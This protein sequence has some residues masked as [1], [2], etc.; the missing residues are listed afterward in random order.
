VS[1]FVAFL[2]AINLGRTRKVPMAE[3]RAWLSAAGL[4]EVESYIQTG[5]LRF[6]TSMR[7]RS[8]VERLVEQ[9]LADAC[10]FDVPT[11]AF[12]PEELRLIHA[13]GLTVPVPDVPDVRRYVTF[14]KQEPDTES[15]TLID[16]WSHDGE[17]ARVRGRAVHWW[18][19]RPNQAARLGNARLEK[20]LGPG[21][22]RDFKVVTT[23]AER[24]GG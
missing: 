15:S 9:V 1:T 7:S 19:D 3:A 8:K 10:G 24:W 17:G 23:L 21:T 14:L 13:D 18:I 11:M 12:S 20:V 16:A 22:T 6:R 4:E 5:N 2:R